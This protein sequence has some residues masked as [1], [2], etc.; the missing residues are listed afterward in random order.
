MLLIVIATAITHHLALII[1]YAED[2]NKLR[3]GSSRLVDSSG[4]PYRGHHFSF[5]ISSALVGV[6]TEAN[7]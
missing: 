1:Y 4:Y 3:Q 2:D 7:R 6:L 5:I